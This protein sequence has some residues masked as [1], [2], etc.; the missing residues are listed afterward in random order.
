MHTYPFTRKYM[1]SQF[2]FAKLALSDGLWTNLGLRIRAGSVVLL[3]LS[4]S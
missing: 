2:H 4:K 3:T 1:G